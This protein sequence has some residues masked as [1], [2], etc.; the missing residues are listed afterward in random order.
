MSRTIVHVASGREW[1]GGQRQVWLL[2]RALGRQGVDQVVVTGAGTE[3][4]G[5]LRSAAI[6]VRP[7]VWRAGLDPRVLWTILGELRRREAVLHAHDAHAVTLAGVAAGLTRTPLVVTRRV[8]FP[9]RRP[10]F[11]ARADR[12]IAISRAV[13][14]ALESDGIARDQISVVHSGIALETTS[15]VTRF[16]IRGQLGLAPNTPVA[17]NVAALV[18]HKD[19]LTLLAAAKRLERRLPDLHW[20]VAGEGE[21]RP[22]LESRIR[23]LE[24]RDRVHL[25]GHI[26]NPARLIADADLFVM[27]SR[28]E[29]LGTSVLDA[30]ALGIPVASTGAGGLPEMLENGAG[31]VVPVQ[32]PNAL[33]DAV[34]CIFSD[35]RLRARLVERARAEVLRFSDRRMAEEVGSVYRSCAHSLGGS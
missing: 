27:S 32:D 21:L 35:S 19:H 24:L 7:A 9:L 12:V 22:E 29:G 25:M 2:A 15:S 34:A 4:A 3:L 11:W 20:V 8:D 23:E 6:P 1:R 18:P 10:G 33:A 17:A 31:L 28:Q 30:M 5:R 26:D 16:G 14:D 13:A